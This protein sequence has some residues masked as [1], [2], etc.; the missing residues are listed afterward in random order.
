MKINFELYSQPMLEHLVNVGVLKRE[1]A[2]LV[3]AELRQ[4]IETHLLCKHCGKF[5]EDEAF[6]KSGAQVSRRMRY[7][8][9]KVCYQ[10]YVKGNPYE[11]N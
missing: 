1:K 3:F 9:C 8:V 2:E 7:I 11:G 6:Y 4:F 10:D 5:Y